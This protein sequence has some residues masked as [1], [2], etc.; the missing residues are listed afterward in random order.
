[1]ARRDELPGIS[2]RAGRVSRAET[3][4]APIR[5][6][7]APG[8]HLRRRD[9]RLR[10]TRDLNGSL[11]SG[12][13]HG[14][15]GAKHDLRGTKFRHTRAG[16]TMFN[17]GWNETANREGIARQVAGDAVSGPD[18]ASGGSSP[19]RRGRVRRD[20]RRR[21]CPWILPASADRFVT[22]GMA[23]R[24]SHRHHGQLRRSRSS[25]R[26][27]C[28]S[29]SAGLCDEPVGHANGPLNGACD[30]GGPCPNGHGADSH[31]PSNR[32]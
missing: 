11:S 28:Q 10:A 29:G 24:K 30:G 17:S 7:T 3:L 9:E 14:L 13:E 27:E 19:G 31:V 6:M 8:M 2:P 16:G 21:E 12:M 4:S 25:G 20:V 22:S 26:R 23:K 32:C 5:Q 18:R 15:R 1:M